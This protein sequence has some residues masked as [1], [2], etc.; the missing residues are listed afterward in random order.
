MTGFDQFIL[1]VLFGIMGAAT[2]QQRWYMHTV[3]V[4]GGFAGIKTALELSRAQSGRITL[5]SE[6][7]DFVHHGGLRHAL[8]GGD[9]AA[10]AIAL[11]DIFASHPEVR[12]VHA[13]LTSINPD[14]KL[15]VCGHESYD[16]DQLVMAL[17][18]EANYRGHTDGP[19]HVF[20]SW[21]LKQVSDLH[22][23]LHAA[24]AG[25]EPVDRRYA[26]IGAGPSGVEIAGLLGA[27]VQQL[28]ERHL[29]SRAKVRIM[30]I[31]SAERILPTLSKQASRTAAKALKK[32]G[33]EIITSTH[34]ATTHT[35]F[36]TVGYQ[37]LPIDALVWATGTHNNPFYAQ[38]PHLFDVQPGGLVAVNP[39]LEAYR[40][41]SVI[42]DNVSVRG[43]GRIRGALDMAEYVADH[44]VR[45]QTGK[46]VSAYRPATS[47]ISVPVGTDW[48]YIE[49]LG[50]Y[51]T[52]RFAKYL[53]DRLLRDS[54]R[55]IMPLTLAEAAVA[56]HTTK[57]NNF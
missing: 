14:R 33:I 11:D 15:V 5:I 56:S 17:G 37:K 38:H 54:Y 49:C 20:G 1:V 30:L 46:L 7:P 13:K 8:T 40:D 28:T 44:L 25:D 21:N 50:I 35:E 22:D 26:V 18:S 16:Y 53:H 29:V 52:G 36:V 48:A 27:Y 32:H 2:E 57:T 24:L 31:E 41:I 6:R 4:G 45:R 19:S 10:S 3:I 12:I 55:R 51:T 47:I 9:P 23:H 42:G 43:S 34:V 39:Y